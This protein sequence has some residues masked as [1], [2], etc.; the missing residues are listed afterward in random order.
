MQMHLRLE[1]ADCRAFTTIIPKQNQIF[2]LFDLGHT[3]WCQSLGAALRAVYDNYVIMTKPVL[4][5]AKERVG[6]TWQLVE[7]MWL[8]SKFI[9]TMSSFNF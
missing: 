4:A 9:Q 2:A 3:R 1:D 8:T 5:M 7:D 6:E